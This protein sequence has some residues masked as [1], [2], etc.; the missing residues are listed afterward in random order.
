MQDALIRIL[1]LSA[2]FASI[3]MVSQVVVGSAWRR[4][5]ETGAVNLRL[6]M[7]REGG[8][9]EDVVA[10]LR[11]N[12]P[13]DFAGW[14]PMIA[15]R[16][17]QLQRMLMGSALPLSPS[18][19]VVAMGGLFLLLCV[20][21]L[22]GARAGGFPLNF[23]VLQM[24]VSVAFAAAVA[25]PLLAINF[26]SQRRRKRIEEQFPIAL[27]VF[28]RALRSGH[29]IASAIDLLTTEM[30]DPIGSE[31][32]L[33]SDE[34]AYGAELSEALEDMAER[35]DLDDMRMFVVSLSVQSET[36]G[37]LAEILQNLSEVIR[38][39]SSLYMKVRALSSEGRMTGWMLTVL[40]I[41][42]FVGLFLVNPRF[43]LDVAKDPIFVIGFPMLIVI[44][45][46]GFI[47][48]RRMVDLKV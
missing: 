45:L 44:Y 41:L 35:W 34:V 29:P 25:L 2:I 5:A 23:G 6:R 28:V 27:D 48:I 13:R 9:R 32:G 17:Q 30:E 11:K 19:I 47:M 8:S 33:V 3:F 26:I 14:P 37:N 18:Q 24:T 38:A 16:L 39:R 12:T 20:L 31:F 42:T 15:T 7:I 4:R 36:G 43:Y 46:I 10:R 40:P 21:L 1:L 22:L